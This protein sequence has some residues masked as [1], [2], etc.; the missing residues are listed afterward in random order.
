IR[1]LMT[2]FP[3]S[4]PLN[5]GNALGH[6]QA[7]IPKP[8]DSDGLL[9]VLR[10]A[11]E[12]VRLQREL[13]QL[14]DALPRLSEGLNKLI[15]Q[16]TREMHTTIKGLQKKAETPIGSALTDPLTGLLNRRAFDEAAAK[17]IQRH[18]RIPDSLALG[19]IDIDHFRVINQRFLLP[20]GDQV[21]ME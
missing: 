15:Q 16:H 5:D 18:E 1:L 6:T 10:S 9:S 7:S 14:G 19:Y 8:F 11:A 3:D 13:E 21:L 2:G 17:K 20:G 12:I 4:A